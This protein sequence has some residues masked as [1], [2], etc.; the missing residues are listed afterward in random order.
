[1]YR[2]DD[3]EWPDHFAPNLQPLSVDIY[4]KHKGRMRLRELEE[5]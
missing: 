1:M 2:H 3:C 4:Y 5:E